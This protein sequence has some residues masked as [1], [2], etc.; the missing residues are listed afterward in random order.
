MGASSRQD[1]TPKEAT[2]EQG[3]RQLSHR[4]ALGAAR[5]PAQAMAQHCSEG[6]HLCWEPWQND[7]SSS[8]TRPHQNSKG[9]T[10]KAIQPA[11]QAALKSQDNPHPRSIRGPRG[12]TALCGFQPGRGH[13][14][15]KCFKPRR[16]KVITGDTGHMKKLAGF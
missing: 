15:K 11:N 7:P 5:D 2:G 6:A 16:A 9:G 3:G 10:G 1:R 4:Q 12:A 13:K 14:G 8:C